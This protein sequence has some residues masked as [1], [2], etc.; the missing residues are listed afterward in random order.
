MNVYWLILVLFLAFWVTAPVSELCGRR[1]AKA[2]M[3]Q[4]WEEVDNTGVSIIPYWIASIVLF[5]FAK[6][7]DWLASPTPW[8]TILIG[9]LTVALL[10]V[11]WIGI[12]QDVRELRKI[13][14]SNQ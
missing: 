9:W 13:R 7:V 1:L 8:G 4:S 3:G 5:G 2:R 14:Q 10:V 11:S 6:A 12:P